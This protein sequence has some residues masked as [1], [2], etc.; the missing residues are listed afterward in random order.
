MRWSVPVDRFTLAVI[1]RPGLQVVLGHLQALLDPP[2]LVVAVDRSRLTD[3]VVGVTGSRSLDREF[4]SLVRSGRRP[5]LGEH[6]PRRESL[7]Q[8]ACRVTHVRKMCDPGAE[9]RTPG[10]MRT[11]HQ[12][13]DGACGNQVR[14]D[15]KAGAPL[16][17]RV[18]GRRLRGTDP[19]SA[20][21]RRTP[22]SSCMRRARQR[23]TRPGQV[24]GSTRRSRSNDR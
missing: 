22:L 1:D 21:T 3:L 12:G 9:D 24:I 13:K 17:H 7:A 18:R 2:E 11:F 5:R 20:R 6:V 23:H 16:L 19:E 8:G 15:T 14:R 4:P 10:F